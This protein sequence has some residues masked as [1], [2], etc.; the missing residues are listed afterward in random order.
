MR[1]LFATTGS[2]G[3]VLPLI[4]LVHACLRTGHEV[5]VA[6]PRSRGALVARAG[7]PFWPL[8]D[9]PEDEIWALFE[10]TAAMSPDDANA[11]VIRDVFGRL[12]A[13]SALP[14][15][16]AIAKA[17]RPDAIVG[18]SYEFASV[19]AGERLGIPQVR[20]ATG[21]ASTEAW[22]LELAG[23]ERAGAAPRLSMTPPGF[24]DGPAVHRFRDGAPEPAGRIGEPLV[25]VTFG[26]VAGGM[27]LF[28][29]L[30][31]AAIE[32]LADVPGRLVVT[33]GEAGDPAALGPLPANVRVERWIPQ[34]ELLPRVS[35]IVCHG[36]YGTTVGA[37]AHGVPMVVL[38]VFADQG[39]NARR[40]AEIGAGIALPQPANILAAA[41]PGAVTGLG[42]AVR[43]VLNEPSYRRAAHEVAAR[44]RALPPV[45]AAPAV[46]EA[47]AGRRAAA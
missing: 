23:C 29:A 37:L 40:V 11:V 9:P 36:G 31:R 13:R 22:L 6:A 46:L 25:Y 28:P 45:D 7:L 4:P 35:A 20:V 18:E 10:P 34:D 47:L 2:P 16:L 42:E 33:I 30:Y 41:E 14:G 26:S 1:F 39:R 8:D 43:R 19:Q 32:A 17:W 5:R 38:P 44:T 21:L 27:P 12:Y 15:L 24:D 3:H